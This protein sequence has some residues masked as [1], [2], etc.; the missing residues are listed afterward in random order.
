MK[1]FLIVSVLVLAVSCNP[2]KGI[3][4]TI[5]K[6]DYELEKQND[7]QRY[8]RRK[9]VED[10]ARSMVAS[11]E[12]DK[13]TY[14]S[15]KDVNKEISLQAKIRANSTAISYNEYILKNSFLW[16]DNVPDDIKTKL[17]IIE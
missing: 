10:T 12:S 1:K 17:E 14:L 7:S 5:N 3:N 15:M 6:I 8:E 13:Q 11:Y 9:Q 2:F 16:A 4:G